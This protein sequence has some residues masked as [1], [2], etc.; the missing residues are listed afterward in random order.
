MKMLKTPGDGPWRAGDSVISLQTLGNTQ[1]PGTRKT[2]S[3]EPS[4]SLPATKDDEK[5]REN[6]NHNGWEG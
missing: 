4:L 1:G 3:D 6:R 5:F 2:V